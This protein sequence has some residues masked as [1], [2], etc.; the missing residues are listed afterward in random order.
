MASSSPIVMASSMGLTA[1]DRSSRSVSGC[2]EPQKAKLSGVSTAAASVETPVI[3]IDS[4]VLPFARW[5][6]MLEMFPPGQQ[7][8]RIIPSAMDGAGSSTRVSR[9]VPA[10]RS[11]NCAPMPIS[12]AFGRRSTSRRSATL[13]SSATPNMISPMMAFSSSR[14]PRSKL[15]WTSSI[16]WARTSAPSGADAPS[17]VTASAPV[18]PPAPR[19]SS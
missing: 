19:A 3:P 14:L 15:S 16:A 11:R 12:G 6:M 1:T 7:A 9:N 18:I 17:T 5:V 8:T 10:G 4:P 13:T 2:S